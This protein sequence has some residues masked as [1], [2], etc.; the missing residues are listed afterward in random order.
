MDS[1]Y[2]DRRDTQLEVESGALILRTPDRNRPASYPLR[3]ISFIVISSEDKLENIKKEIKARFKEQVLSH[4]NFIDREQGHILT[5]SDSGEQ[6]QTPLMGLSIGAI[7]PSQHTFSD[8]REITE[9]ASEARR[10]D[11]AGT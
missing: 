5:T 6:Q 8:I 4:Y 3:Q 1:L 2:I 10:L 11:I 9:L 7:S